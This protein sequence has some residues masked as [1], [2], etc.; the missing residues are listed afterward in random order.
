MVGVVWGS[1]GE[2]R[3]RKISPGKMGLRLMTSTR[4]GVLIMGA[5]W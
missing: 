4:E 5:I 1:R 2:G 3:D